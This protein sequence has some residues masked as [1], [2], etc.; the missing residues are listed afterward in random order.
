MLNAP[1]ALQ[2]RLVRRIL[3][4]LNHSGV[5]SRFAVVDAILG[6]VVAG[7]SGA[8]LIAGGVEVLRDGALIRFMRRAES[9]Q[10][11]PLIPSDGIG[12]DIPGS[13]TWPGTGERITLEF[14]GGERARNLLRSRSKRVALF[15]ASTFTPRL[16]VR[17]WR[18]GDRFAPWG[19]RGKQKKLQD[20]FIDSKLSRSDRRRVPLL[21]APEG[22]LWVAGHRADERFAATL[23]TTTFVMGCISTGASTEGRD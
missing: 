18:H 3:R 16:A 9:G 22:I 13:V 15:D 7:S 14:I 11:L 23:S 4:L 1:L 6:Q 12:I 8:R 21:T 5:A 17:G 2:R 20:F 19:L 10:A